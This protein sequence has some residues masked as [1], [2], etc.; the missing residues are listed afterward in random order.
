M[1]YKLVCFDLDG[2]IVDE[3]VYIWETLH[4]Y[5]QTDEAKR[6]TKTAD[7]HSGKISYSEWAEWEVNEWIKK[8][9]PEFHDTHPLIVERQGVVLK[10][11]GHPWEKDAVFNGGVFELDGRI[12]I[13][14]RAFGEDETSTW[15]REGVSRFGLAVSEDGMHYK[16]LFD[17]PASS[18]WRCAIHIVEYLDGVSHILPDTQANHKFEH[19]PCFLDYFQH[20]GTKHK[21]AF[22]E[23]GGTSCFY[24]GNKRDRRTNAG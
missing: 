20:S 6:R 21:L 19:R 18:N 5:F 2:T 9:A 24:F 15:R 23:K 10:P 12:N 13:L 16:R 4:E 22:C 8:Y 17:D 7:F 11:N 14:Y 1:P 3:T